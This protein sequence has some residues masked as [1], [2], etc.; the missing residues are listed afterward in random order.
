MLNRCKGGLIAGAMCIATWAG[1][2]L[3]PLRAM[4]GP[5]QLRED[6]EVVR[7]S[8]QQV[9]PDPYRYL[10]EEQLGMRFDSAAAVLREPMTAEAFMRAVLPALRAIGDAGTR[11]DPST[12]L[13]QAYAHTVPMIPF[14]VSVI[15]GRLYVDEELKGFRSLP[16]ACELL[17]INGRT[18]AELLALLR[19]GQVPEGGDTTLLDRG[20]ERDFPLLYRR[21]VEAADR[22]EVQYRGL[23]GATGMRE[24]FALTKDEMARSHRGKGIRMQPWR[25]EE[26]AASHTAW[27]TLRTF[28]PA[29]LEEQRINPERFLSDV[30]NALRKAG[31]ST[32]VIDVRGAQGNDP[33]MAEQVFGLIAQQPYRVLKSMYVRSGKVPDSYRYAEP[34]PGF[35]ASA[36]GAYMPE[37]DGRRV[38]KADDPR[39]DKLK[40]SE[41]AFQGKVYVVCNGM[42]TGAA[43]AFAMMAKRTGR[44]RTVGE[45]TGSNAA[46][47]CGGRILQFTL[48]NTGCVLH[49]PMVCFVP[50]GNP[51]GPAD[52][53][54]LPTYPVPQRA[55]DLAQGRDTVREALLNLLAETQ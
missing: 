35:F 3:D 29:E 8:V 48:P 26:L 31:T 23:E 18:A 2:Q 38:L 9:H 17:G 54:E 40:P 4:Y 37:H 44:G 22:F 53:G 10:A 55:E 6:L 46:A 28:E 5:E 25:L 47:F 32:L 30:L 34:A 7:R 43:A 12:A 21:H 33:G 24:V 1:A 39:L 50:E 36:E 45:E 13:Q 51:G 16:T 42:T 15:N 20:I 52:R 49:V 19:G 41:H 14:T 27:L 11:L